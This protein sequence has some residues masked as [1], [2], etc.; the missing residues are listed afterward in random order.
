MNV[1][2]MSNIFCSVF[3][4][5]IT[6]G[7]VYY[8]VKDLKKSIDRDYKFLMEFDKEGFNS[9]E[10]PLIKIKIFDKYRYFLVDSGAN[11]NVLCYNTISKYPEFENLKVLNKIKSFV[12]ANADESDECK[13]VSTDITINKDKF[14]DEVFQLVNLS[15]VID[16]VREECGIEFI[17]I[18]GTNFF[19]KARWMLDFEEKVI[20]VKKK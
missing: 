18:L 12:G 14:N 15:G 17:G 16:A 7:S 11:D 4:G 5:S 20:W 13:L 10:L 6:I 9:S 8:M 1:E 19:E 2:I 3:M